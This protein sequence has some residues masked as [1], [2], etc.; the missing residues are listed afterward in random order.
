MNPAAQ[1]VIGGPGFF[2]A[3]RHSGTTFSRVVWHAAGSDDTVT[4]FVNGH[5]LAQSMARERNLRMK[6]G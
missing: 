2:Y 4:D 5:M 6:R 3:D 1:V